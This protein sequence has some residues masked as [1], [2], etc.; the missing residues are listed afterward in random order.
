[1]RVVILGTSGSGKTTFARQLAARLGVPQIELDAI[2]WQPGWHDL[3]QREPQEF[4]R[5]VKAAVA[6][7]AWVSDGN[8]GIVRPLL[9]ARAT[10]V[11]GL[12][13]SRVVVMRRVIWR[14]LTRALGG[15]ELWPGTGNKED[16]RR[17]LDKTHPIRWA[18]DTHARR[19]A[20]F[21]ALMQDPALAHISRHRLMHP[22]DAPALL[23]ALATPA[24]AA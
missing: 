24:P 6:A 14:S 22:G 23:R 12:D 8:Y 7:P 20:S 3:S 16:F 4:A 1:M 15:Q 10:H 17:W 11:V 13:Y 21:A 5:R 19:R 2:N 18:W 9:L